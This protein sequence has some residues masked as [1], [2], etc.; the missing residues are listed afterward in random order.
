MKKTMDP[1]ELTVREKEFLK[2]FASC[3]MSSSKTAKALFF[4]CNS[5]YYWCRVIFRKTG[6]NPLEF[7]DLAFL[8]SRINGEN[9]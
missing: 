8:I 1:T 9:I 4:S 2:I 3:N 7:Y 5:V 6:K